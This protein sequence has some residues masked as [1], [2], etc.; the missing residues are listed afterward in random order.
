MSL[1]DMFRKTGQFSLIFLQTHLWHLSRTIMI[2]IAANINLIFMTLVWFGSG[3]EA[4]VSCPPRCKCVLTKEGSDSYLVDCTKLGLK[5][6][7]NPNDLP[8]NVNKL[9]VYIKWVW[10]WLIPL[11]YVFVFS[12]V[13]F[14]HYA[15]KS[16]C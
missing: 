6:L 5:T 11:S 2:E 9:W 12:L 10:S 15:L 7:I 13:G 3:I 14:L 4:K 1:F 16:V 8:E